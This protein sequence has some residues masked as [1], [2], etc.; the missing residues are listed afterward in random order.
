MYLTWINE[1][2]LSVSHYI[3]FGFNSNNMSNF[4]ERKNPVDYM[5]SILSNLNQS[6]MG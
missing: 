1:I 5:N 6:I 2:N 4:N 3:Y